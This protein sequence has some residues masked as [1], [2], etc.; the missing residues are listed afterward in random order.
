MKMYG[1]ELKEFFKT[2]KGDHIFSQN[3]MVF[4]PYPEMN[5]KEVYG[6]N[7]NTFEK[8]VIVSGQFDKIKSLEDGKEYIIDV[9]FNSVVIKEPN[10]GEPVVIIDGLRY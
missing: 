4:I 7:E 6:V 5:I 2:P 10:T 8:K 3:K 9:V 1:R